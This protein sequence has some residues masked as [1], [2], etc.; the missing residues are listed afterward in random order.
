MEKREAKKFPISPITLV[1]RDQ[2]I[3][4]FH[5]VIQ[6]LY[7][8][9]RIEL[10]GNTTPQLLTETEIL[11]DLAKSLATNLC[12]KMEDGAWLYMG[13]GD[14]ISKDKLNQYADPNSKIT[15]FNF[16]IRAKLILEKEKPPKK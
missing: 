4:V 16:V 6:S 5:T 15:D 10:S 3:A 7:N 13:I 8:M 12:L 14:F 2:Q 1:S 11:R 9:T